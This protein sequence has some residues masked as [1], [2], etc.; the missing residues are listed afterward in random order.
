MPT[1]RI[2][3]TAEQL[4][5]IELA[6]LNHGHAD[7]DGEPDVP[8]AYALWTNDLVAQGRKAL[9]DEMAKADQ[10]AAITAA[11]ATLKAARRAA[12]ATTT[13]TTTGSTTP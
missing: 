1:I 6:A 10:T 9:A 2:D 13:T 7:A 4:R 3:V 12:Q 8:A 5:L 11:R